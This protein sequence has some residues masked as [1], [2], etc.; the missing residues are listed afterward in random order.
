MNDHTVDDYAMDDTH[1]KI[2]RNDAVI[3]EWPFRTGDGDGVENHITFA[4]VEKVGKDFTLIS[5]PSFYENGKFVRVEWKTRASLLHKI[6]ADE[7]VAV[8]E[9][10]MPNI[11]LIANAIDAPPTGVVELL[12]IAC[13][14]GHSFQVQESIDDLM[15]RTRSQYVRFRSPHDMP[16][17]EYTGK[18]V[19]RCF[20]AM[21]DSSTKIVVDGTVK[22]LATHENDLDDLW[23]IEYEL[24]EN[25]YLNYGQLVEAVHAAVNEHTVEQM[26]CNQCHYLPVP[27][28]ISSRGSKDKKK[29]RRRSSMKKD[30][31]RIQLPVAKSDGCVEEGDDEGT[32]YDDAPRSSILLHAKRFDTPV[33][34]KQPMAADAE[35]ADVLFDLNSDDNSDEEEAAQAEP[36]L[37]IS[38]EFEDDTESAIQAL[39]AFQKGPSL[40]P[41]RAPPSHLLG[42]YAI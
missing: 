23:L 2:K 35:E 41:Q 34:R 24:M 18:R 9:T 6:V 30:F 25:E 21:N 28:P 16:E 31:K 4:H 12:A 37:P 15:I 11:S 19:R 40:L 26:M 17:D 29:E 22:C 3:I 42:I 8:F 10:I 33:N 7:A 5:L 38:T 14:H 20:P 39:V 13:K 1:N 27:K 36:S 32:L